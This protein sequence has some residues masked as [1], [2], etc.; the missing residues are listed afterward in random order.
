MRTNFILISI[1]FI[2]FSASSQNNIKQTIYL[3][4]DQSLRISEINKISSLNNLKHKY[5]FAL[6]KGLNLTDEKIKYFSNISKV[7]HSLKNIFKIEI[8]LDNNKIE[9]LVKEL[10]TINGIL[11]CYKTTQKPIP[12]PHDISPLTSNFET[13]QTYIESDP[14]VNVRYA[15]N[16]GVNGTGINIKAIEY[17]VN[18][19]H[20]DLD[21]QNISLAP[22][23]TI[24][25]SA[26]LAYTEHGTSVAGVVFSNYGTYGTSG[27]AHNANEYILYPEWTQENNYDRVLAVTNAIQDSNPGDIIIYEMQAYGQNSNFVLAEFE[28]VIW[29]L[30][31]AATDAGIV[32]I[33][34]AG[35]GRENLDDP[36]YTSYN[37]RGDSGAIIV[38]AGSSNTS[39]TPLLFSTFGNRVN[40]QGWGQNVY[41]TGKI[42]STVVINNDINQTYSTN[43]NGTSSATAVVGGFAAVLQSYYL[44]LTENHLTSVQLRAIMVSTGIPQGAGDHIGP[45]PNMEAA[46]NLIDQTLNTTQ[47]NESSIYI[48]PNPTSDYINIITHNRIHK[49]TKISLFNTLGQ[50]I[51]KKELIHQ[52]SIINIQNI[53]RGIYI[54]KLENGSN[55]ITKK[56][57]IN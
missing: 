21:H 22:N 9:Q 12:P 46:M 8:I 55:K 40:V 3:K 50:K 43:F 35:N 34:A 7:G 41:S 10:N 5:T 56:I 31:K 48:G 1:L 26:T 14:G 42:G 15:W 24:N 17:G 54:L 51:L 16:Q 6:K 57:I 33:A 4:F 39:H 37:N 30:T 47:F 11:Y 45:L 29:D 28:Q 23:T 36:F 18:L 20:E 49:R 38:G 27:L 52:N 32:I 44:Q 19:S 25:S 53:D 2:V 13:N